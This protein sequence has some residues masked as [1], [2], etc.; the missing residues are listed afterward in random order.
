MLE[1]RAYAKELAEFQT[2]IDLTEE[3]LPGRK[4]LPSRFI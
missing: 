2:G 1:F 3:G 4:R